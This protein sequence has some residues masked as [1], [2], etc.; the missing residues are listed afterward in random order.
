M[1]LR[2]PFFSRFFLPAVLLLTGATLA[3]AQ[4]ELSG[5]A[6]TR[7]YPTGAVTVL[8]VTNRGSGYTSAPTI[9]ISGGGG[10]GATAT[11][12]VAG[13]V[14]T[15]FT[16]TNV[17]SG[18]TSAPTVAFTG[19]GGTGAAAVALLGKV[20][21]EPSNTPPVLTPQFA[22]EFTNSG[23]S[24]VTDI[25][26][27]APV[28]AA[29]IVVVVRRSTFGSSFAPGVPRY[30][31]GDTIVPPN[32][33]VDSVSIADATYWRPQ[34]VAIGESFTQTATATTEMPLTLVLG[35][36]NVTNGGTGYTST[37]TVTFTGGGG[38]GAA[39]TVTLTQNTVTAI[40]L[41]S[42][43]SGY[44]SL[45]GITITGGG[46]TGATAV[47]A[48]PPLPYYYSPHAERVFASQAGRV[49]IT[50]VSRVPV[51]IAGDATLKFR[52]RTE[53]FAVSSSTTK[54]A[55]TIYWTE[56][57][58][59][60]PVVNIPTG[61][62]ET[63]NP[64]YSTNF[65]AV[66][67]KEYQPVGLENTDPNTAPP[68]ELRTLWFQKQA[69]I[70]QL[71]AYNLEGR[72]LLEYLGPL[73]Q[74]ASTVYEFLGADVVDIV[75]VAPTVTTVVSLG[76]K[77]TPRDGD[78]RLLPIDN[79]S[80]FLA[81]PVLDT[82]LDGVQYY[83]TTNRADGRQVYYAERETDSP[84]RV[85]FYWLEKTDAAIHF[86]NSP[87]TPNLGIYWPKVKNA[88]SQVWP[89]GVGAYAH[90]TV[91][92]AGSTAATGLQFAAGQAPQIVFQDDPNQTQATIDP[93]SQRL[94]VTFAGD[95]LNRTLLKFTNANDVWY[96]RLYTQADGSAG[97]LEGDSLAALSTTA[98]V[99][100]RIDAPSG[101]LRGGYIAGGTNYHPAA[102]INPFTA[103]AVAAETGAIIPVNAMP[104][105]NVLKIWWFK[106]VV[107]PS[108]AFEAFYV[109]AK[110]GTYTVSYPTNPSTIVLAS[111]AG[112][113][114][115]SAA[116]IAGS[117]Y[118]Q[119]DRALP[120][121]N[122]NEEHAMMIAGRAYALRDDL[123][124]TAVGGP[125]AYTSEPYVLVNYVSPL[126]ARPALHAFK[127][128]REIRTGNVANDVAFDY[129]ITAGTILQGPMPLPI[130]PLPL[131]AAG[132]TKNVE[133]NLTPDGARSLEAPDHYQKFTFNDRKG[134]TWVYRAAHEATPKGDVVRVD[135]TN[136]GS[137]YTSAPA[138]TI[139]GG[140]GTGGAAV[141]TLSVNTLTVGVSGTGYSTAPK[142]TFTGGGGG[143]GAAAT[144]SVVNRIGAINVTNGGSGYT[145]A[146][147][148]TINGAGSGATATATLNYRVATISVTNGG[149][150][151]LFNLPS[152][153][154]TGGGGTGA[155][156][157]A[158][159]LDGIIQSVTVTNAGSGYTS[160]P[161]VTFSN[162]SATA[163]ATMTGYVSAITVTAGG[164]G[165]GAS[166]TA[167]ISGGGG[168]GATA[169]VVTDG[170]V[171]GLT[172]TNPGS[173][174][175]TVPTVVFSG[176]GTGATAT[177]TGRVSVISVTTPGGYYT[178]VPTVGI[179]GGG[180]SGATATAGV[181][182]TPSTGM[183]F[184]YT[185]REGFYVP[186]V[187][188]QPAIGTILPYLRPT[189]GGVPQGDP[190]TGTPL[191]IT[192][193]PVWPT[194]APELRVAETL[195]LPKFGLPAV[196][197]QTSA[198]ILY[199]QSIAADGPPKASVI[200]HDPIR[201]KTYPLVSSGGLTRLP[202][203]I[204]TTAYQGKTYFQ[205]LP[206]HL[207]SRFFYDPL[208]GTKGALVLVGV[209]V[210]EIAGEDYLNLNVLSNDDKLALENLAASGDTDRSPWLA[211]VSALTTN[212]ETFVEDP[213]KAGTYKSNGAPVRVGSQEL[214]VVTHSDTAVADYALTATGTGAGWVTML[215][216]DGQA[217]TP[218]GDPV[219]LQVFK[220]T[221]RLNTGELKVNLSS[222]PLDEK[223]SLRHSA[224][225]AAKPEDYE[226]EWRYAPPQDGVAPGVYSYAIT[227]RL[228]TAWRLAQSPA[229]VL[230][231]S[232]EYAAA[233]LTTLPRGV[234]INAPGFTG[235]TARP[236]LVARS[237]AGVNFASG[238]P[239]Q[240]Y[241]SAEVADLTGFVLYVNGVAALAYNAPSQFTNTA[242]S[243]GLVPGG[244]SRQFEVNGNFF[245]QGEN[246]IEVALY[247]TS[248]L[249]AVSGIDF[250]LHAS[251]ETDLVV[252]GGSPWQTP[253]GT[254]LNQIVVG[255]S[256]TAP[257]GSPLLVLS[258]NYFTM[259]YRPKTV[260]G[261]TANV[262]G[263]GWSR[264][265]P[266]KLVE[267][268]IKRVLAGINPF[269]QRV[270]DLYNNA[271]NTDVS[272]L[273]QAGTR[274]E[275]N[276]A[277]SL[278]SI[279][280]FGL[281]EIYETVLN[282]GKNISIEAGYDYAP[283]NDALLLAAGYLNDL[284]TIL[285][286]EAYAD[287]ANPT[288]SVDGSS[289]ATEVNT[290]RFSFEGQVKS[291]LEEEL[292]LLRGRDDF[293]SPSVGTAPAYNRLYWNYTRGIN[294]GEALY[295][296]N[297]N[298]AEK[299]GSPT[300]N[301]TLDAADAQRM[302]PQ[303]HG[304][305]YGHYLTALKGYQRLLR[306]PHFSWTPRSEAVTVLGQAIQID[307]FDER[308]FAGAAANVARSAQQI[309]ALTHRQSYQDDPAAG[310]SHFRDGKY[311]S[312]TNTTR[313]WGLDEWTSRA[314]QGSYYNWI[315]GNALLLPTDIN[316]THTGVQIIDRTTVPELKELT[317]L[318]NEF[319]TRIDNANAHLNP[320]GLSPGAIAFDISASELKGGKSHYEQIYD[321]SL[322]AALNAK[323]AFDQA[324]R[325]TRLLRNQANQVSDRNDAI[326]DQE[327]AYVRRLI[328]LYGTPYPGEI[329]VGKTYAQG[330]AGPDLLEWF[331]V[332]RPTDVLDSSAPLTL[333]VKIPTAVRTFTGFAIADITGAYTD[334]MATRT[335]AMQ[336]NRFVQYSDQWQNGTSM[337]LRSVTGTLQQALLDAEQARVALDAGS[338]ALN[339]RYAIFERRLQLYQEMVDT[340]LKTLEREKAASAEIARLALVKAALNAASGGAASGAR[341][342]KDSVEALSEYMPRVNGLANDMTFT[343]R[344]SL[345]IGQLTV[346][347]ILTALS[348]ALKASATGMEILQSK[349]RSSME[350]DVR[351]YAFSYSQAQVAYEYEILFRDLTGGYQEVAQLAV[352]L[353]R[354]GERVRNL[355]AEGERIQAD[356]ETFRQRAAAVI[357]GYRTNDLTFRTFRN[358]A[359]EQY[360]SLFDLAGRYS[361]LAAKSYDYETGLL[362]ST[363]GQ[364]VI[365]G[366]V[367]SRALGDLTGGVP[368]ATVST[369]GD[370]GLAGTMARMQADWSVAKGRLGIN[371]PDEN[372]TLFSLRRELY[373]ILP[374]S[375]ED[376][377]WQQTLEQHVMS[378]IMADP[379]VAA[380]A[381]NLRKADGSAVPGIV[382][383]FSTTIQSGYNFFGL[384][385]AA[386]DHAFTPSNYATKIYSVGMVLRGYIGMDPYSAGIPNAGAPNSTAANAL[387]ATPYV[388][389]IPTGADY[390]IAPPLGDTGTVRS[391]SVKDQAL[392]LPFNLG[393]T[394][395][396]TTQFFNADGTLSESPWVLRKHQAF[397]PVNDPAFF[398][399]TVP[400]EFTSSRLVGRSVWN[401][402]WKIVIPANTLFANEQEG[403]SRFVASVKDI[404][405]FLRT[406]SHSGN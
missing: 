15:G 185:M 221:P 247:S 45:P 148:V 19:G 369:L 57:S 373:R 208:R 16:V 316:P 67:A 406:Y 230:P 240:I 336:P 133:V 288:I 131:D 214:A 219:A 12:S 345:K 6:F 348:L 216:G 263:T 341:A 223:V 43:G 335:I 64:V 154:L 10:T 395:F 85:V 249:G 122:P 72:V 65:P 209:F 218:T 389:L 159:F 94:Q 37:P 103:G 401:G 77:I 139:T 222:N 193:R 377:A 396:S 217:F 371:N 399:T 266:A 165:F 191:R 117:L 61:K 244:L 58:F 279:N 96:V 363:A 394:S 198:N 59:N 181:S 317:A 129:P 226:F 36:I 203:S 178:S 281:I 192:Y 405:L 374:T 20:P 112:S 126:D 175:S 330:Y 339:N 190:V 68:P 74:G 228:A 17:G 364:S 173:G 115:L 392:P 179:T 41:T 89:S 352:N 108:A 238:V 60:G 224:D 255:G 147:T 26:A 333:S 269:N 312:A 144:A 42:A 313:H 114:D 87:A 120:G 47:V 28:Y 50:W 307:Y 273:T 95:G 136:Q 25:A 160:A 70:G 259:R 236:G 210:D 84:E 376:T 188:T 187:V 4:F 9:D 260:G 297:Y 349:E 276:V 31:L 110:I 262:A 195:T 157:R 318:A 301:G 325:M 189:I 254:Y 177:A 253:N 22:V 387:S 367:A 80:E 270:S 90:Y 280:D 256:P 275:G 27:G 305:A 289:S 229:G 382:I 328:E 118:I 119:N 284:Y 237:E 343:I 33:Q 304:D 296:T 250:R 397:R 385:I 142:V 23:G 197:N 243:T 375:T 111:N 323:G 300:A 366:I 368:Q 128:L 79:S 233:L 29:S 246:T 153:T 202:A 52:F 105:E 101:Y 251:A 98:Q 156:A 180:G 91:A 282:R 5:V 107:P 2:L 97:F 81:S 134:Y 127:V 351:A 283:A 327:E 347:K 378:N 146:P 337:G 11:A 338:L 294:S 100:D 54:P 241:F 182:V 137:G 204:L 379:D 291:V 130:L 168:T 7:L 106:K 381:R 71:R 186:G 166:P 311:N 167:T 220:V 320:L 140:G 82:N 298:I 272:L 235:G 207:Q 402:G 268:W 329:G 383:P 206:P 145:S 116:E 211:A 232:G 380:H 124:I 372:G 267:G 346:S 360:R 357:Q 215:F 264:W 292:A 34:P 242:S 362:G 138:V 49:N 78:G 55:R 69:G 212:V 162:G 391:W 315:V 326:V 93:A 358:E 390:M 75:R 135:V 24:A 184:Y 169:S 227:S 322:R 123:N 143:S 88:Y 359:L 309:L 158:N 66:V 306:S 152:V 225:F 231:T 183:Q 398:Y 155:T 73:K 356:R 99:G 261:V 404:E 38:T 92:T 286:N 40:N 196:L 245:Q 331:I 170:Y 324:A 8:S 109:P 172:I 299:A 302:F 285:G 39:A 205:G 274:W 30:L 344:G 149:S 365:S 386:G 46:G 370:A 258:D 104:G 332:D 132:K 63:L 334:Q 32:T 252:A 278:S 265:M 353:Q 13:G 361:Y 83:G 200:L 102:Y 393:A 113:G 248:D 340:H 308:K 35:S 51:P 271:V 125:V 56:R 400:T 161:T 213:L 234:T 176:P 295:A 164:A 319:Q 350:E 354:A 355:M 257:L 3:R 86:L 314:S 76:E 277:L 194:N 141:A 174:Y 388:Y 48:T 1:N 151:T 199:Q 21:N 150:Y 303:G 239:A 287:A 403:L 44:T 290:S 62:I 293:L 201:E 18:Y 384:P 321:R 14:V 53:S 342:I 171:S 121:F 163:T 310:W